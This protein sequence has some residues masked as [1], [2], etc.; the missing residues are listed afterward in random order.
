MSRSRA[1]TEALVGV[2]HRNGFGGRTSRLI[3]CVCGLIALFGVSTLARLRLNLTGSLPIGLYLVTDGPPTRGAVVL[4]CLPATWAE[5]ARS[6]GYVPEGGSCPGGTT[7]IG[8]PVFAVPGDTVTVTEAGLLLNGTVVPNTRPLTSDRRGRPLPSL[9]EGEHVVRPGE[10]WV[11][12]A[13]SG[14]SFDSRY[15][16]VLPLA[17]VRAR[18]RILL[19]FERYGAAPRGDTVLYDPSEL[20]S[21]G[22]E[23]PHRPM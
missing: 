18:V 14:L 9:P 1:R 8:K 4:V 23:G 11:V 5:F 22:Y 21:S 12:S 16:G 17:S 13:Y 6:R 20:E 7:P 10:L 15:F 19:P 3:W 2:G